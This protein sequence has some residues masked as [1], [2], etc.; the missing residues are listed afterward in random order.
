MSF[1]LRRLQNIG[2]FSKDL[3][4][5]VILRDGSLFWY[6]LSF[7]SWCRLAYF[8]RVSV[9]L[10]QENLVAQIRRHYTMQVT[11]KLQVHISGYSNLR[12]LVKPV[13]ALSSHL[14]LISALSVFSCR[15]FAKSMSLFWVSTY[16]ATRTDWFMGLEK[17]LRTSSTSLTRWSFKHAPVI[18]FRPW[19]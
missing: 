5:I 3:V 11:L 14:V 1:K 19:N 16:L 7:L 8:E 12:V 15:V 9:F 17:E 4:Y 18:H 10:N 2:M 6:L 13:F